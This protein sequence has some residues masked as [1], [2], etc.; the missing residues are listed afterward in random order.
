MK[1]NFL[2]INCKILLITLLLAGNTTKLI[3]QAKIDYIPLKSFNPDDDFS[4]LASLDKFFSKSKI[5]GMGESTHGTHEFFQNRHRVFRYL[6]ENHG[7]TVFFLE[8]DY[9]N[10]LRVNKYING[11]ND[12]LREVVKSIDMWPWVTEEMESLIEWMRKYNSSHQT[13]NKLQFI[14]CD[15][16]RVTT[17][18][19]EID[20]L[21]AKYDSTLINRNEYV[22]ITVNEFLVLSDEKTI[23]K[24]KPI[25]LDK[26]EQ[27]TKINFEEKDKFI[28]ETLI[29]HLEQVIEAKEKSNFYSYRDVKMGENI[30][31]HLNSNPSIKGF[32]W[33]HNGH[34]CNYYFP[35]K[36]EHKS[37]YTAGGVLKKE[38]KDRYFIIGQD[39]DQGTFN[40]YHIPNYNHDK[41]IDLE[42]INNY[43]LGPVTVGLNEKE[44]GYQFKDIPESILYIHPSELSRRESLTLFLHDAGGNYIP[45]K[46]PK[47]PSMM[48]VDRYAFDIVIVIK[49]TTETKLID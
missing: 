32:Y 22:D 1:I 7:F 33:A 46:N 16:Q 49:N 34:I 6:V 25:I 26:K 44:L 8:A 3:C 14:G 19:S 39:F 24:Y 42:D 18:I 31:Y 12:D 35:K 28:Y 48:L 21:I 9:S 2:P 10:C 5:V 4:D 45:P 20:D 11:E 13:K 37:F 40:A 41:K 29:R 43:I 38:L 15:M 36:K 27:L 17:T 30:L 47:D 23:N